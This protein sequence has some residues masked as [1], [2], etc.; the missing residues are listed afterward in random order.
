MTTL[1]TFCRR[2][3]ILAHRVR[4]IAQRKASH[5][6]NI[7]G[8]FINN[9]SGYAFKSRIDLS[10]DLESICYK[11]AKE[12]NNIIPVFVS[13]EHTRIT[14]Y[15]AIIEQMPLDGHNID[16]LL[17]QMQLNQKSVLFC[18]SGLSNVYSHPIAKEIWPQLHALITGY[19]NTVILTDT[20][21]DFLMMIEGER[22]WRELREKYGV[23]LPS[24]NDT[25]IT[26]IDLDKFLD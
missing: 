10:E 9:H 21:P 19:Y 18:A 20:H 1:S 16:E 12:T 23:V 15:S 6:K 2:R 14:P 25:K 7:N 5:V 4:S 11:V 8:S 17:G 26:H 3:E 24:L 13:Y 22:Y